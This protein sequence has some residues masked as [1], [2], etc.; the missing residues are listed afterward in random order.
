MDSPTYT[1][2]KR[3]SDCF[4]VRNELGDG[5]DLNQHKVDAIRYVC[6]KNIKVI[7]VGVFGVVRIISKVATP[8]TCQKKKS[9]LGEN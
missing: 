5:G 1:K 8:R 2:D 7:N 9:A 3:T 6:V 4:L